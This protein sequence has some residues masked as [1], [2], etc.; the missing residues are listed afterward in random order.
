MTE[1]H[2]EQEF[3]L[4]QK[5]KVQEV[6]T[7]EDEHFQQPDKDETHSEQVEELVRKYSSK[8]F[9]QA[10]P[11]IQEK[12]PLEHVTQELPSK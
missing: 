9:V 5:P 3:P 8:H 12:Q 10:V 1:L 2:S 4:R 11:F 7:E 6:Q